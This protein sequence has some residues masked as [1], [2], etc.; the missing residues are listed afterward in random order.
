M[1]IG[2]RPPDQLA[3]A[4]ATAVCACPGGA[5]VDAGSRLGTPG[6]DGPVQ[7]VAVLIPG[8]VPALVAIDLVGRRGQ[9]LD[10]AGERAC[11]A[12]LDVCSAGGVGDPTIEVRFTGRG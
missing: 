5:G 1:V 9:P 11:A 8:G 6:P 4:I 2:T 7:G 12:A 3:R 10:E